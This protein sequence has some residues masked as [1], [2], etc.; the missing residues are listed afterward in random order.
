MLTIPVLK[1]RTRDELTISEALVD[2]GPRW[3]EKHAGRLKSCYNKARH[4]R[5]ILPEISSCLGMATPRLADITSG[6]I[7]HF[8]DLLGIGTKIIRA[9]DL[10]P[11]ASTKDRMLVD[12]CKAVGATTYLSPRGSAA[13]I[14]E[15]NEGGAF[16]ASGIEL[17][18]QSYAHPAYAQLGDD[19]LPFMG[20]PD[21]LCNVGAQDAL[22]VIRS[23]RRQALT[24]RELKLE[25]MEE[26][27]R[28]DASN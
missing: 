25:L 17:L 21:L 2:D 24:S 8:S 7:K 13:Y 4:A 22:K 19:F 12:V 23:G 20:I 14:E 26:R 15:T 9:S 10:G 28:G 27:R 3:R 5:E 16:A 1:S 6:L 18:Y 11:F